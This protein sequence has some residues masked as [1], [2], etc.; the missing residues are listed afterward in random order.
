MK[1][2]TVVRIVAILGILALGGPPLASVQ[3]AAPI[4]ATCTASPVGSLVVAPT[5]SVASP[6]SPGLIVLDAA[7][8]AQLR[9]IK[10]PLVTQVF[11]TNLSGRIIARTGSDLFVVD[12]EAG[13]AIR[14]DFGAVKPSGLLPNFIQTRGSA[15]KRFFILG[16]G[17]MANAFAVD[18]MTGVTTDLVKLIATVPGA[19]KYAGTVA[20]APGDGHIV[21]WDGGHTFLTSTADLSSVEMLGG[22]GFTFGPTFNSDGSRL[23]YS[24]SLAADAGSELVVQPVDGSPLHVIQS[25]THVAITLAV[26]GINAL[27]VDDR[28][29]S[30]PGGNLSLLDIETGAITK[31]I[32]YTG[33]ELSVQF[34]PDGAYA[35]TGIDDQKGRRWIRINLATGADE[36]IAGAAESAA[37]PGLYGNANWATFTPIDLMGVGKTGGFYGGMNLTTG[38][39]HKF[40]I[41]RANA[42]YADPQL[43]GDGRKALLQITVKPDSELWLLDNET[44]SSKLLTSSLATIGQ[45]SPDGCWIAVSKS[46]NV[47]GLRTTELSLVPTIGDAAAISMPNGRVVAWLD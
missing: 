24:R 43:S 29:L 17:N 11:P 22:T 46:A 34:T 42:V 5:G 2:L 12:T 31:L 18:L 8:G 25:S 23:I 1:R 7:T 47:D 4:V 13:I 45:F 36:T 38:V 10:I 21:I 35:I 37:L 15:G 20:V 44:G 40:F 32:D 33:S 41:T 9:T 3:A 27:L 26:P 14:L 30:S 19:N 28:S 39:F 6:S 16:D